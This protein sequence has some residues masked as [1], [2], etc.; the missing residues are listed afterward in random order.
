M[1][2]AR[3]L[4]LPRPTD[5][6]ESSTAQPAFRTGPGSE[7]APRAR[8]PAEDPDHLDHAR[9]AWPVQMASG[10]PIAEILVRSPSP[11]PT[12]VLRF[13][14]RASIIDDAYG[15]RNGE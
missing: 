7:R 14:G 1:H 3:P 6:K 15:A 9:A 13:S 2:H 4:H 10:R 12:R 11:P 5:H 8:R